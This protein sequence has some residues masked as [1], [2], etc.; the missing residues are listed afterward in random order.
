MTTARKTVLTGDRPTGKLH[1]GHYVGSLKNRITL[2]EEHELFILVANL[3]ALTTNPDSSKQKENIHNLVLD[4]LAAGIDEKKATFFLQSDVPE[5]TEL[6]V[7]LSMLA[8]HGMVTGI[9]TLKDILRDLKIESPSMGLISYPVL[10]AADILF[11]KANIVP[12]GKDQTSHVE[13]TRELARRFNAAYGETFPLPESLIP[14]ENGTLPGLD[15]K[16]KMS[17][18][19]NNAIFLS[20]SVAEV[21]AKVKEMYTDPNHIHVNDPGTVEGNMVFS[22]LDAF[23]TNPAEVEELKAQYR[24]GGLGDVVIKKRLTGVLNEFLEPIRTR[25]AELEKNPEHIHAVLKEGTEK[26][27][28][29]AQKTLKEVKEKM[30]IDYIRD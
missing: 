16:A 4:Q 11:A 1:L 17:K 14:K 5:V 29:I 25:R 26:A 2:Q 7:I 12:V 15:G 30:G 23:D 9:P 6:G 13:L 24:K 3:H 22:Y 28:K 27:R 19:L 20:D 21:E 10:M 8:P 18:S